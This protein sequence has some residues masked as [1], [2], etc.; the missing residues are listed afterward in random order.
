VINPR[1]FMIRTKI[2]QKDSNYGPID[3]FDFEPVQALPED[4]VGKILDAANNKHLDD[5]N[6]QFDKSAYLQNKTNNSASVSEATSDTQEN[7]TVDVP[8]VSQ[9]VPSPGDDFNIDI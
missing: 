8:D 7:V 5:F 4:L 9:D 1:R 3:I 2:I 6:K